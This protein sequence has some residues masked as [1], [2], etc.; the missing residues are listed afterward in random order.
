MGASQQAH[1]VQR[2]NDDVLTSMRRHVPAGMCHPELH[3]FIIL[4]IHTVD[5][6]FKIRGR[7][8]L[9][10]PHKYNAP[11][12]GCIFI[13]LFRIYQRPCQL[14]IILSYCVNTSPALVSRTALA[15]Y[16]EYFHLN[17]DGYTIRTSFGAN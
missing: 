3:R 7:I 10:F 1:N 13:R 12:S 2:C 14:E 5:P 6:I 17:L 8:E 9:I 16:N 15:S 11:D 4:T